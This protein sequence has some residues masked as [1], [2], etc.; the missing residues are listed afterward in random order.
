[1]DQLLL[2]ENWIHTGVPLLESC[3]HNTCGQLVASVAGLAQQVKR[4]QPLV[5]L[6]V[7]ILKKLTCFVAKRMEISLYSVGEEEIGSVR[8]TYLSFLFD[9]KD[10]GH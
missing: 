8:S 10:V 2:V 5:C 1:M 3:V 9:M 6:S 7:Y 4:S